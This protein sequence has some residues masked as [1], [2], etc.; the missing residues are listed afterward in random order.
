MVIFLTTVVITLLILY[1]LVQNILYLFL[2]NSLKKVIIVLVHIV[3]DETFKQ[4]MTG[5]RDMLVL[6]G[7]WR[8]HC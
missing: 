7:L 2:I 4:D 8:G 6:K 5:K 3:K 1:C